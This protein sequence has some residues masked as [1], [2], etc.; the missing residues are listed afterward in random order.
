MISSVTAFSR[1]PKEEW[2]GKNRWEEVSLGLPT[3]ATSQSLSSHLNLTSVNPEQENKLQLSP[4]TRLNTEFHLHYILWELNKIFSS[5]R[6]NIWHQWRTSPKTYKFRNTS[7]SWQH[8]RKPE[9]IAKYNWK[10]FSNSFMFL[11]GTSMCSSKTGW[12]SL[13]EMGLLCGCWDSLAR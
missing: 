10:N 3:R 2:E 5:S 8:E 7:I 11:T 13:S 6:W 12:W 1:S 4:W 9:N